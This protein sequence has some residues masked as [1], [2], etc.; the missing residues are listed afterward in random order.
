MPQYEVGQ[1]ELVDVHHYTYLVDLCALLDNVDS[2]LVTRVHAANQV[3]VDH[4]FFSTQKQNNYEKLMSLEEFKK[5]KK[6]FKQFI[7]KFMTIDWFYEYIGLGFADINPKEKDINSLTQ[8]VFYSTGMMSMQGNR[9]AY[10]FEKECINQMSRSNLR[11]YHRKVQ[12]DMSAK[13]KYRVSLM[14]GQGYTVRTT[15]PEKDR[16]VGSLPPKP[17]SQM[18]SLCLPTVHEVQYSLSFLECRGMLLAK[19]RRQQHSSFR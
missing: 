4:I 7:N 12:A 3:L 18:L 9:M 2:S 6:L 15:E 17:H 5:S 10:E 1:Q 14:I 19:S 11:P 16:I 13:Q 8:T